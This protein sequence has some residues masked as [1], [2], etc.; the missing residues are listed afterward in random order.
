MGVVYFY[1]NIDVSS[2]MVHSHYLRRTHSSSLSQTHFS[3]LIDSLFLSSQTNS[4]SLLHCYV[5]VHY[6]LTLGGVVCV[7]VGV[8]VCGCGRVNSAS[9]S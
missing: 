3:S 9:K 7:C 2:V 4:S 1:L 5:C 6:S 8:Y